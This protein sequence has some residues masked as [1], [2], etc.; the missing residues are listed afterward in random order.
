MNPKTSE[1]IDARIADTYGYVY[2]GYYAVYLIDKI[3]RYR[4]AVLHTFSNLA[5]YKNFDWERGSAD[6]FADAIESALNLYNR[7]I[8]QCGGLD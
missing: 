5:K 4:D 8:A 7:A 3:N 1:I 2:N 6:G